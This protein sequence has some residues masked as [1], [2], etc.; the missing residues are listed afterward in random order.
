MTLP[1][2]KIGKAIAMLEAMTDQEKLAAV[3]AIERLLKGSG[4]TFVDLGDAIGAIQTPKQVLPRS[5]VAPTSASPRRDWLNI[6]KWCRLYGAGI[7]NEREL[8]FVD[9]IA[10]SDWRRRLTPRQAAW[11]EVIASRLSMRGAA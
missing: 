1:F 6:A 3:G 10:T 8:E 9:D 4:K 5:G 11:L 7:L 2:D